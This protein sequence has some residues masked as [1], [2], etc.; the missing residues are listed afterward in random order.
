MVS[1]RPFKSLD[2]LDKPFIIQKEQEWEYDLETIGNWLKTPINAFLFENDS[3]ILAQ[4]FLIQLGT[5]RCAVCM[6]I[7]QNAGK[8]ARELIRKGLRLL[9]FYSF[10]R[11]EAYV[12]QGFEQGQRLVELCGFQLEGL[13]RNFEGGKDYYMYSKVRV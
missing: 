8:Q 7:S 1:I 5:D 6:H 9:D 4:M 2:D 12:R 11:Y 10:G 13:M 3:E